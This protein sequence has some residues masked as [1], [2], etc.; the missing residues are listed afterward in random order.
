MLDRLKNLLRIGVVSSA[1]DD[2]KTLPTQLLDYHGKE[3][4][5]ITWFPYGMHAVADEGSYALIISLNGNGEE[6]ICIP[7]S[8]LKRP[9]GEPGEV[10]VY[11]PL[12]GTQIKLNAAGDVEITAVGNVGVTSP[13]LVRITSP[14]TEI[15]GNL[16]VS[17]N[18]GIGGDTEMTGD[19][20]VLT[21]ATVIGTTTLGTAVTSNGVNIS[22]DHYHIYTVSGSPNNT[23]GAQ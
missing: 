1:G 7:T 2:S 8:M 11:H 20:D 22:D 5:G 18:V 12:T 17:G 6:R 21:N 13:T 19:L 15:V 3:G 14:E 16:D 4:D 9:K 23:S 10:F